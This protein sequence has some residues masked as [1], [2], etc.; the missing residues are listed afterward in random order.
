MIPTRVHGVID[1][2]WGVL[3]I[4][5]PF[6]FGFDDGDVA[7]WLPM[8]IG[9]VAILYSLLTR[10]EL[11]LVHAIPMSVHLG[12]DVLAGLFLAISP[13]LFG[14]ADRIWWPHLVFGG[15]AVIIA[16]MTERRPMLAIRAE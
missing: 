15:L 10:Y 5:A 11:G 7:Q 16:S 3:L 6:L 14:F 4:A 2:V 8:A 13:W 9:L 12:L 1:Y